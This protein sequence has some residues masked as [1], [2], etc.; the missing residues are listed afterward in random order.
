MLRA[1]SQGVGLRREQ[2]CIASHDSQACIEQEHRSTSAQQRAICRA[3]TRRHAAACQ[4]AASTT[5]HY[6]SE[7]LQQRAW[8]RSRAAVWQATSSRA[9]QLHHCACAH[10][11]RL[12]TGRGQGAMQ[13]KP[14]TTRGQA[15]APD[16]AHGQVASMLAGG[17]P[18][19]TFQHG[20]FA[21][22]D[23]RAVVGQECGCE[24]WACK[25]SLAV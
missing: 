10:Q 24:R 1:M 9:E 4:A 20:V 6:A 3:N 21:D 23:L 14:G 7:A 22:F 16:V 15:R 2:P 19:G 12:C 18:Q 8:L 11:L 13:L 5:A 25:R 17:G